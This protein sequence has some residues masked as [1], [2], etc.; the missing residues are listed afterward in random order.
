MHLLNLADKCLSS[1]H[2]NHWF[3]QPIVQIWFLTIWW[4]FMT[5][6]I[7]HG[8]QPSTQSRWFVLISLPSSQLYEAL[9][10]MICCS[11]CPLVTS[12]YWQCLGVWTNLKD[13]LFFSLDFSN[14]NPDLL[15]LFTIHLKMQLLL[16]TPSFFSLLLCPLFF[17]DDLL[18]SWFPH[19]SPLVLALALPTLGHLSWARRETPGLQASVSPCNRLFVAPSKQV[20]DQQKS[21]KAWWAFLS[22]L[23][24]GHWAALLA[25]PRA[26]CVA[27]VRWHRSPQ[28]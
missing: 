4:V 9:M 18:A 11:G 21:I 27:A 12:V 14:E 8:L 26:L 20:S 5:L 16:L 19:P 17:L 6:H 28:D 7:L 15:L 10:F 25:A 1:Q 3:K 2:A 22:Q 24:S 23:G 13:R